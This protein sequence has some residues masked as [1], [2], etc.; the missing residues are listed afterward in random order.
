MRRYRTA[1]LTLAA[2]LGLAALG[3]RS[4]SAEGYYAASICNPANPTSTTEGTYFSEGGNFVN[5]S[6][7]LTTRA[8]CGLPHDESLGDITFQFMVKRNGTGSTSCAGFARDSAG[9]VVWASNNTTHN[10]ENSGVYSIVSTNNG[11]A[12]VD[13]YT[14][15]T[16]CSLAPSHRLERLRLY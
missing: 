11:P 7:T 1:A 5:G 14:Y 4:V 6:S 8:R 10:S 16:H 12:G 3:A 15:A 13:T 2:T 9:N